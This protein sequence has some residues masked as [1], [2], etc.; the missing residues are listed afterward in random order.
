MT[1]KK[2]FQIMGLL[3]AGLS[4]SN[5]GSDAPKTPQPTATAPAQPAAT[6]EAVAPTPNP[7]QKPTSAAPSANNAPEPEAKPLPPGP[8]GYVTRA[9]SA[10]YAEPKPGAKQIGTL[11]Q[12][13]NVYMLETIMTDQQGRPTEYPTWYR[14]ETKNKKQGWMT[15]MTVNGGGGG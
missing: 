8:V 7:D 15:A 10:M 2:Y 3:V 5:C 14:I 11:K 1:I 9:N 4:L 6:E 13:E 12:Y